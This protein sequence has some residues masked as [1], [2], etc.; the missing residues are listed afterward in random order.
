MQET[1][2]NTDLIEGLNAPDGYPTN[3]AELY[4]NDQPP[5]D[6][7][8]HLT[9]GGSYSDNPPLIPKELQ[10]LPPTPVAAAAQSLLPSAGSSSLDF[11][12]NGEMMTYK[13][14]QTMKRIEARNRVMGKKIIKSGGASTTNISTLINYGADHVEI[15]RE[16]PV[17]V[18][19]QPVAANSAT[20]NGAIRGSVEVFKLDGHVP[21]NRRAPS[22]QQNTA[23][24]DKG[25]KIIRG[26]T[27][28]EPLPVPGKVP[29]MIPVP[30][31]MSALVSGP[32]SKGASGKDNQNQA[33]E[34][35]PFKRARNVDYNMVELGENMM[36]TMPIV[37]TNGGI[38]NGNKI[39]GVLYKYVNSAVCIVCICH[40]KFLTPG[41]FVKHAGGGDVEEPMK[42]I[43]VS[44]NN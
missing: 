1:S 16:K 13:E 25:K 36:R 42:Y 38:P 3:L 40:G 32:G 24:A 2:N 14:Y 28:S 19:P 21:R 23:R 22:A 10:L 8:L 5:P 20:S 41:E 7:S 34:G 4:F 26:D 6:L 15:K 33:V 18:E 31:Q 9:L 11:P 27:S 29:V 35:A 37:S 39:E 43:K 12:R 44:F 30:G 17:E